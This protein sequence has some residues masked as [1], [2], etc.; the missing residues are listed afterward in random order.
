MF[1]ESQSDFAARSVENEEAVAEL[2]LTS[3]QRC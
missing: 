1:N 3:N 2:R